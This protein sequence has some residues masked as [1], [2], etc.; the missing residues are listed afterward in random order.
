MEN[1]FNSDHES[2]SSRLMI[3]YK[4]VDWYSPEPFRQSG[5]ILGV[6]TTTKPLSGI[7]LF[8]SEVLWFKVI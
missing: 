4:K 1:T 3:V 2:R 7:A 6:I 5:V 8:V